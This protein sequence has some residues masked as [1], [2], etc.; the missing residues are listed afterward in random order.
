M[1]IAFCPTVFPAHQNTTRTGSSLAIVNRIGCGNR[2][3]VEYAR[4][5]CLDSSRPWRIQHLLRRDVLHQLVGSQKVG[6]NGLALAEELLGLVVPVA[7][8]L[9]VALAK[10]ND[11]VR[12]GRIRHD[13]DLGR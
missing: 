4:T 13:D 3:C 2:W 9:V 12:L 5:H 1:M 8:L 10:G 6:A 11:G 7:A